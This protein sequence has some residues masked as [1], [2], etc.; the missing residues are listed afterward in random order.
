MTQRGGVP[1]GAEPSDR[2]VEPGAPTRRLARRDVL[3]RAALASG[4]AVAGGLA[5]SIS[6]ASP[7][8][9]ANGNAV[10]AGAQT[11][12]EASTV[13]FADGSTPYTF[14][15]LAVTDTAFSRFPNSVPKAA[16][17]GF[18]SDEGNTGVAGYGTSDFGIGASGHAPGASGIGVVGVGPTGVKGS[19]TDNANV[20]FLAWEGT[21]DEG[22]FGVYALGTVGV[23]GVGTTGA[24]VSAYSE[25]GPALLVQ[26]V[27]EFSRS[28]L[29]TVAGTAAKPAS[30]VTVT[31]VSLS[32]SSLVLATIQQSIAGVAVQG[33]VKTVGSAEFTI[34]L[35]AAVTTKVPVAWFVIG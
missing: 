35:T 32:S 17:L 20:G 23:A 31:G 21:G 16:V 11:N 9:A 14:G 24:G 15:L 34:H 8:G 10:I 1:A 4:A 7:A 18:T 2:D 13:L 22:P 33:V 27:A 26:G 12:A 5:T 29:A 19:T 6:F 28:G 3:S 25:G 30:T